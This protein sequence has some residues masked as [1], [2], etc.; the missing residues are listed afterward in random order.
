M[1]SFGSSA[2]TG[3]RIQRWF[4]RLRHY[5]Y[6]V[7]HV[8]GKDNVVADFLSRIGEG[9]DPSSEP[10]LPNDDDD[11]TIAALSEESLISPE[12]LIAESEGDR[13]FEKIR[14][15][16]RD[17]WPKRKNIPHPNLRLFHD[18][19]NELSE[20]NGLIF[21]GNRLVIPDSL[22]QKI[23][24]RLH[25]G[26]PGIVRMKQIYRDTYFWPRGS[27]ECEEFVESCVPCAASGK[28]SKPVSVPT[29]E[30]E[31]PDV[32]F[33]KIA[34]DIIGPFFT[35][36]K[37]QEYAVILIDYFS[38]WPEYFLTGN[39]TSAK[40]IVWLR[41]IF[42]SW[43][44]PLEILSDNGP[45]FVSHEFTEFLASKSIKH[46]LTPV[47]C[48]QRNGLIERFNRV[49]KSGIEAS[50]AAGARF[51]SGFRDIVS[52][53]RGTAP[54]NGKSPSL[55]ARGWEMRTDADIRNPYLYAEGV[56]VIR[57][58]KE[59]VDME[60]R[61]EVVRA[62]AEKRKY[63]NRS[64]KAMASP[65]RVGD[66]VQHKLPRSEYRKGQSL[67]S[68][69]MRIISQ[70]G[71]WDFR[72]SDGQIWNAR[73]LFRYRPAHFTNQNPNQDDDNVQDVQFHIRR[74]RRVRKAPAR[75]IED[76]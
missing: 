16:F 10:T 60:Q 26:H 40:I 43:G 27:T 50:S 53:F 2:T 51:Q 18:I 13:I 25:T 66:V 29:G 61:K 44:N 55:L 57:E 62:K 67:K 64:Q 4:D 74:S 56:E 52:C 49:V 7:K 54:E 33:Q 46:T 24:S 31:V 28:S 59:I 45:Q 35:A 8:A 41:D 75:L 5:N 22:Q 17:G 23:L 68:R 14:R 32:P 37:H 48:P 65:F 30:S 19:Q 9:M 63:P 39:I 58:K 21:R 36:P 71:R 70:I 3:R 47:Y 72:L 6:E 15:Y 12:E 76:I 1:M 11:I 73:S 38:K 34:I 42:A 20:K 69:P